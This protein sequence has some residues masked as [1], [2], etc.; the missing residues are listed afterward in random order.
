VF[1]HI[2]ERNLAADPQYLYSKTRKGTLGLSLALVYQYLAVLIRVHA[3]QNKPNESAPDKNAMEN[4]LVEAL[5]HFKIEFPHIQ[6]PGIHTVKM[7]RTT[8]ILGKEE[9]P[10][11]AKQ[12]QSKVSSLGQWV[13]GDEKLFRWT[14]E[15]GYLRVVPGK[16]DYIGFWHYMMAGRL[17]SGKSFLLYSKLHAAQTKLGEKVKCA[18]VVSEWADIVKNKSTEGK[19]ILVADSYYLDKTGWA[20]LAEKEVLFIC[21]VCNRGG[22]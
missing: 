7:L 19:T 14:G 18:E 2:H 3:L 22:F 5:Q 12:Y 21:V 10:L 16:D 9:E 4:N 11:L 20:V 13:A 6:A 1:E 15:S 8:F 17:A